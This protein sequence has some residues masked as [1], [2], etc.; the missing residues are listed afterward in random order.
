MYVCTNRTTCMYVHVLH[1][2]TY[3]LYVA[4]YILIIYIINIIIIYVESLMHP[5]LEYLDVYMYRHV[6][7]IYVLE[8]DT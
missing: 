4:T 3:I 8:N 2:H 7:Y 6:K 5:V 1:V